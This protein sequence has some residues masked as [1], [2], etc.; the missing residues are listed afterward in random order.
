MVP[1]GIE[2]FGTGPE[3]PVPFLYRDVGF[4]FLTFWGRSNDVSC[5]SRLIVEFQLTPVPQ[6]IG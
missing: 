1:T 6:V 3:G 2:T 5:S 4:P